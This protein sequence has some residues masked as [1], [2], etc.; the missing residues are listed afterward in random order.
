MSPGPN[1]GGDVSPLSHMDRRPWL[2]GNYVIQVHAPGARSGWSVDAGGQRPAIILQQQTRCVLWPTQCILSDMLNCWIRYRHRYI[3]VTVSAFLRTIQKSCHQYF[4]FAAFFAQCWQWHSDNYNII[5][6]TMQHLIR[7]THKTVWG[8]VRVS[9]KLGG[10]VWGECPTPDGPWTDALYSSR[11]I[12]SSLVV[13]APQTKTSRCADLEVFK[14][15][16]D[17]EKVGNLSTFSLSVN[18]MKV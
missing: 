6:H 13:F 14:I 5:Y 18:M 16:T 1:I 12:G 15:L 9:Q 8:N 10:N 2:T 3:S 17:R 4:M 11:K 7:M